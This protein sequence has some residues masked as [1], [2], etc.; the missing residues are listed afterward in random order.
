MASSRNPAQM[1][2]PRRS[3]V[4][5]R[6]FPCD[7]PEDEP[8]GN[9]EE[10]YDSDSDKQQRSRFVAGLVGRVLGRIFTFHAWINIYRRA[11]FLSRTLT[12]SGRSKPGP[13]LQQLVEMLRCPFAL[14]RINYRYRATSTEG[15][16]LVHSWRRRAG[17]IATAE[18]F[19]FED[20]QKIHLT[21]PPGPLDQVYFLPFIS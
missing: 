11:E 2:E 14:L 16:S 8:P 12:R 20:D 4:Y 6:L 21:F 13:A 19:A 15:L 5:Q 1:S 3:R 18:S 17:T 9:T 7:S 10:R